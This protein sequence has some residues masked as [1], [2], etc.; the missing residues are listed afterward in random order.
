MALSPTQWLLCLCETCWKGYPPG[1]SHTAPH[2]A[3]S[4]HCCRT[5][6]LTYLF[7]YLKWFAGLTPV[8]KVS[9]LLLRCA[10]RCQYAP[11]LPSGERTN[12][13]YFL[14][15]FKH[16]VELLQAAC[17]DSGD[18]A[19]SSLV[20]ASIAF[21]APTPITPSEKAPAKNSR[22]GATHRASKPRSARSTTR[23][24]AVRNSMST[25]SFE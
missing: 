17:G 12:H 22:G 18:Y 3:R 6:T 21:S 2:L 5:S 8:V 20:K 24:R 19:E 14:H 7:T 23:S 11:P 1:P 16:A 10:Y 9:V 25:M 15:T 13:Q 4:T